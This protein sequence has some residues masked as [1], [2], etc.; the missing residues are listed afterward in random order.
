MEKR[1]F[2]LSTCSILVTPFLT[3]TGSGCSTAALGKDNCT[4]YYFWFLM[5]PWIPWRSVVVISASS[6]MNFLKV[7]SQIMNGSHILK[8]S[9][10]V[11]SVLDVVACRIIESSAVAKLRRPRLV[12]CSPWWPSGAFFCATSIS[13]VPIRCWEFDSAQKQAWIIFFFSSRKGQK[14]K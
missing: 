13:W 2:L 9:H 12:A 11:F 14:P 3:N 8:R 1:N 4:E 10:S 5:S 6:M 7:K